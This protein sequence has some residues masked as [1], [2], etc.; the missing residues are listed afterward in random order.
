MQLW[1]FIFLSG[2]WES[3]QAKTGATL[4]TLGRRAT[5]HDKSL[6]LLLYPEGTL[7]SALQEPAQCAVA[8]C[9]D[10]IFQVSVLTRPKSLKFA[11]NQNIVRVYMSP[12]RSTRR[13]S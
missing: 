3:D 4:T 13:T 6:A 7:V 2:S 5:K 1:K 10:L 12:W 11:E 8:S 9:Q